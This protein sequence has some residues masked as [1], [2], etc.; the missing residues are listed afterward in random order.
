M[1]ARWAQ[2]GRRICTSSAHQKL[3]KNL[4]LPLTLG[5][6]GSGHATPFVAHRGGA[7]PLEAR[8]NIVFLLPPFCSEIINISPQSTEARFCLKP[9]RGTLKSWQSGEGQRTAL[10][11]GEEREKRHSICFCRSL[12][13]TDFLLQYSSVGNSSAPTA[14]QGRLRG[15]CGSL[16]GSWGSW[17]SGIVLGML[18]TLAANSDF[19]IIKKRFVQILNNFLFWDSQKSDFEKHEIIY[20][21]DVPNS[22]WTNLAYLF[23]ISQEGILMEIELFSGWLWGKVILVKI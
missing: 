19:H 18:E 4:V 10:R 23:E 14:V 22:N 8:Q 17:C 20:F 11:T 3:V 13:V 1:A 21:H 6:H 9:W 7:W 12:F 16:G 2:T 5:V 15:A